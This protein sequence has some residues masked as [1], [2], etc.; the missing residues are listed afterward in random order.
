MGYLFGNTVYCILGVS[1]VVICLLLCW[2]FTVGVWFVLA[3]AAIWVVFWAIC[4]CFVFGLVVWVTSVCCD[5]FRFVLG[6][7]VVF[8]R[9]VGLL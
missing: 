6:F 1:L 9:V 3:V 2:C 7:D 8:S 4:V 5:G